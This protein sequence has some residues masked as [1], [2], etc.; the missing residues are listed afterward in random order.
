MCI[1]LWAVASVQCTVLNAHCT[2]LSEHVAVCIAL[3]VVGNVQ[4]SVRSAECP[5]HSAQ[6]AFLGTALMR[7]KIVP[8]ALCSGPTEQCPVLSVAQC[9][10]PSAQCS[11]SIYRDCSQS[12]Q[13]RTQCAVLRGYCAV[14][15]AQCPCSASLTLQD[16]TQFNIIFVEL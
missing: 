2:V 6:R 7:F 5:V 12:L 1:A 13:D 15:S 14:P 16:C 11:A 10:V 4:C 8:V 9:S 3:W